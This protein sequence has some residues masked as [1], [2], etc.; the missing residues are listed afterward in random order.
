MSRLPAPT[1][2][3]KPS[4]ALAL[5]RVGN[6]Y[7][8]IIATAGSG[9]GNGAAG[10]PRV[11]DSG[12]IPAGDPKALEA[13]RSKAGS[14][15]A[16]VQVIPADATILR[17]APPKLALTG[18]PE[19][20]AG[21]LSLVAESELPTTVPAHRRAAGVLRAGHAHAVYA[22]G[23][24]APEGAIAPEATA[25]PAV[26]AL[27]A[28]HRISGAPEGICAYTDQASGVVAIVAAGKGE[29]PRLFVRLLRDDA[30]DP[31]AF[32]AVRDEAIAD[33][34]A[35][36]ELDAPVA[37]GPS[38]GLP[39]RPA[40]TLGLVGDDKLSEFALVLGAAA[41]AMDA[42]PDELPLFTMLDRSPLAGRSIITR[43][44]DG[45]SSPR[46]AA[47]AAAA[48]VVLLLG[49]WILAAPIKLA[50]LHNRVGNDTG[51]YAKTLQ[52]HDWYKALRDKRWPMTALLAEL[53]SGAPEGVRI[54]SLSIEQGRPVTV[55]GTAESAESLDKWRASLQG[56]I[57]TEVTP[58]IPDESA[59]PIRFTITA[60][61][62]DAML[63]A[64]SELKPVTVS[65]AA[66]APRADSGSRT[67]RTTR[68]TNGGS[69]TSGRTNGRTNNGGR[70]TPAAGATPSAAAEPPPP[71]TDAQIDRLAAGPAVVEWAKRQG[72]LS[73]SDLDAATR[74]RL[75]HERDRIDAR[76]KALA[77]GGQ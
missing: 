21:A 20:I 59:S 13:L 70:T 73:R 38:V 1:L 35:D 30:S 19:Q 62:A 6:V 7:R 4:T 72:Q 61:V 26:A 58:N 27:A 11:T 45:L 39:R 65:E 71:L 47:V 68:P 23:W 17:S 54:E 77:G 55:T 57:F 24:I 31:Q 29:S 64:V 69:G 8:Y 15:A 16:F 48:C 42:K 36:L 49:G 18:S 5:Q 37:I 46:A 43:I 56:K 28:L 33:A 34:Q 25:V 22:V 60:K 9:G 10:A 63:A 41:A 40:A 51:D 50:I 3:K 12:T 32:K 75:E 76:R 52:Q 74:T 44:V 67:D 66:R 2:N 14:S 53:T